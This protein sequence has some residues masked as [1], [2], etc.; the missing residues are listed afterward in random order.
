MKKHGYRILTAFFVIVLSFTIIPVT[1]IRATTYVYGEQL[2]WVKSM[3]EGRNINY[4]IAPG[5]D[6]TVSIPAAV[7]TLMYP[8]GSQYNPLNLYRTNVQQQAKIEFYRVDTVQLWTAATT[9]YRKIS[10]GQYDDM[11]AYEK[12]LYDW[13]YATIELCEPNMNYLS[14]DVKRLIIVHEMLHAYG[15]KDLYNTAN[16]G[17]IMY[18]YYDLWLPY[19]YN[20]G[21]TPEANT[22]LNEKY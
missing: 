12:N 11:A 19:V 9:S 14:A 2:D 10:S 20:M 3:T 17:S 5:N 1:R 18:G 13:V 16:R 7:Q 22:I 4:W 21:V 6:Y 8:G 15:L